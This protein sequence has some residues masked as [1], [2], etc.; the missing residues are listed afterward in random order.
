MKIDKLLLELEAL[1]EKSGYTIRKERGAFRGD[2]CVFEGER[3]IVINKNRPAETRAAILARV[4][5]RS[6]PDE[7]FIKP[8]VRKELEKIWS[9]LERF[10]SQENQLENLT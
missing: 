5:H 7:L 6:K 10:E 2:Q 8:A 9:K 3:L 1:C 4:I